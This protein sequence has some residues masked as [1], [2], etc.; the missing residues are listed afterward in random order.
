VRERVNEWKLRMEKVINPTSSATMRTKVFLV[1][2][3]IMSY[4]FYFIFLGKVELS[5]RHE[6]GYINH[7]KGVQISPPQ[8]CAPNLI[9]IKLRQIQTDCYT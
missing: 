1:F 4:D 6:E 7:R 2:S 8:R 3:Q 9:Q 5:L